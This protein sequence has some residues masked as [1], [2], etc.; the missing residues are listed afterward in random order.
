MSEDAQVYPLLK[1]FK[2]PLLYIKKKV[3]GVKDALRFQHMKYVTPMNYLLLISHQMF[4]T[5]FIFI[6]CAIVCSLLTKENRLGSFSSLQG[7]K[8]LQYVVG[9]D[10]CWFY[11]FLKHKG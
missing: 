1:F 10:S 3:C 6:V 5:D 4:V 2:Q 8:Q 11:F 7:Q 9:Q